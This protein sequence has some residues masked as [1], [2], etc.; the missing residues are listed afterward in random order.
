[1]PW[2]KPPYS[3]SPDQASS[4]AT[5]RDTNPKTSRMEEIFG[6]CS[7]DGRGIGA[8][9]KC[10][11]FFLSG[12]FPPVYSITLVSS[13]TRDVAACGRQRSSLK[14][15]FNTLI[16]INLDKSLQPV[17]VYKKDVKLGVLNVQSLNNKSA[18]FSSHNSNIKI[19]HLNVR[20]LKNRDHLIEMRQLA[21]E[22]NYDVIAFSE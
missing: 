3:R 7:L 2:G 22:N 8:W 6:L 20:S 15:N 13:Q 12:D 10:N 5:T 18:H 4:P 14:A 19:A 16:N 1:M 17:S 9:P 11:T 21:H